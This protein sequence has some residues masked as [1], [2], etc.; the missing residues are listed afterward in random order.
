MVNKV[1][2]D[3]TDKARR[4]LTRRDLKPG[5]AFTYVEFNQ[6]MLFVVPDPAFSRITNMAEKDF[7]VGS[8]ADGK[9]AGSFEDWHPDSRVLVMDITATRSA[10]Q[11]VAEGE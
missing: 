2:I 10:P 3:V 7:V 5:M 11:P 9:Y 8:S 6:D 1:V 4:G